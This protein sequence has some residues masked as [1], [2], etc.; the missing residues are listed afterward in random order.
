MQL[1]A[2]NYF[3]VLLVSL[4]LVFIIREIGTFKG[5]IR[6][7]YACTPLITALVIGFVVLSMSVSGTGRYRILVMAALVLSLVADTLLMIIEVKLF[8]YGIFYFLAAHIA[9]II[10][11]STDYT[12]KP[13]NLALAVLL[14][15]FI[16][17]FYFKIKGKTGGLDIPILVYSHVIMAMLFFAIT[18]VNRG[19]HGK[20]A[21]I[22]SGAILFFLSDLA[23]AYFKFI[24]PHKNESVISWALY[25]PAQFLIALSCF[26]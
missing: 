9:Y 8:L 3:S 1:L 11:F 5:Y 10:A 19:F 21:F 7:K 22:F 14:A 12:F 4:V 26:A 15:L 16:I 2:I 25:C 13:W 23:L 24:K 17:V 20:S 6:I 18:S